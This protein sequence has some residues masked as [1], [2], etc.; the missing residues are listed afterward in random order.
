MLGG[1]ICEFGVSRAYLHHL[2]RMREPLYETLASMHNV[3]F[4]THLM[5]ELRQRIL[6]D[7][8]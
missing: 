2:R 4:M 1:A 7:E 5:G 8:I 3:R 6:N